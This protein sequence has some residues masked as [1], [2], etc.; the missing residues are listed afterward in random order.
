MRSVCTKGRD[1]T[2]AKSIVS[3]S[4]VGGNESEHHEYQTVWGRM[5]ASI[6]SISSGCAVARILYPGTKCTHNVV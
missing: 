2:V 4:Q 1:T 6:M 3:I 5:K